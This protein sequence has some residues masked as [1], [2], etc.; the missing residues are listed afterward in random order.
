MA[1]VE[2]EKGLID[3]VVYED[4][5]EKENRGNKDIKDSPTAWILCVCAVFDQLFING[6]INIY[7]V[8]YVKFVEEF[9]TTKAKAAWL[10]SLTYGMMKLFAPV[11]S[12][13]VRRYTNRM[14]MIT[15][16]AFC[17]VSVF[18][19]SFVTNIDVMF[20]TF[21]FL[22]GIGF[23]LVINP[24]MVIANGYFDKY[25]GLATGLVC[26]GSSLGTITLAPVCQRLVDTVGWRM[27]FRYMTGAYIALCFLNLLIKPLPRGSQRPI[28]NISQPV[29]RGLIEDLKLWKNRVFVLW[30]VATAFVMFGYFIPNV[31]LVSYAMSQGISADTAAYLLM[32]LGCATTIGRILSGKIVQYGF[33]NRLHLHQLTMIITGTA[34][35]I[36]PS[37]E[38]FAG[39]LAYSIVLGLVD[40]CYVVLLPI[41]TSSLIGAD[42]A[43]LAWCFMSCV[44]SLTFTLGPPVSGF[45][46][47]MTGNYNVAFHIAGIPVILG[48]AILFFVPWAQ[49]TSTTTNVMR[50]ISTEAED[51]PR[52][53]AGSSASGSSDETIHL[54]IPETGTVPYAGVPCF[55]DPYYGSAKQNSQAENTGRKQDEARKHVVGVHPTGGSV[56]DNC[57][58]EFGHDAHEEQ[59]NPMPHNSAPTFDALGN[60]GQSQFI[61]IPRRGY[62]FIDG[63]LEEL[64]KA[65]YRTQNLQCSQGLV[66]P[67][68]PEASNTQTTP[69]E[70]HM[71]SVSSL[72]VSSMTSSVDQLLQEHID[73]FLATIA[74]RRVS[75]MSMSSGKSGSASRSLRSSEETPK[76]CHRTLSNR[77][78]QNLPT[79]NCALGLAGAQNEPRTRSVNSRGSLNRTADLSLSGT[80]SSGFVP[81]AVLAA[82]GA[83][84]QVPAES[85]SRTSDASGDGIQSSSRS[86][87]RKTSSTSTGTGLELDVFSHLFKDEENQ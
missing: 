84:Q 17:A 56:P 61:S 79:P 85:Q 71:N 9:G 65:V 7:G 43:V 31:H 10:G 60:L 5:E 52:G 40:G 53:S 87:L 55:I 48:A 3:N 83:G 57:T 28:D 24:V 30:A 82:G 47:D 70:V 29:I 4:G 66:P 26:A 80:H 22:Y 77:S 25:L 38:S 34:F 2:L 74:S 44:C 1:S 72:P 68:S 12:I 58:F 78:T 21:P 18:S 67:P 6:L 41:L 16:C 19:T 63:Y 73:M 59:S 42:K 45:L 27:T 50:V 37:I 64:R 75:D 23:S 15:G 13:L 86:R 76:A 8:F 14:S 35:M 49:R 51:H 81:S 11:V 32:A 62:P 39:L 36:L 54:S 46:C 33:L 69:V 20:V